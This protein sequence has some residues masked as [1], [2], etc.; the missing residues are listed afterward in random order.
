MTD[1]LTAE[2]R[3]LCMS[4]IGGKNTKPEKI[5]SSWLHRHGYRFRLH[6]KDLPGKPDIVLP[7]YKAVIFVHGC[8]WHQH[9]GCRKALLPQTNTD[10]W[11]KKLQ[12]NA[13]RDRAV[14]EQLKTSGWKVI[15]VWQC[16]IKD[17]DKL[18]QRLHSFLESRI[19]VS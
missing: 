8:F 18:G 7:K 11:L 17:F 3:R 2:Q 13:V 12:Q 19:E 4:R 9:E 5:V 14:Q 6:R 15:V 10:F 16:E 1:N